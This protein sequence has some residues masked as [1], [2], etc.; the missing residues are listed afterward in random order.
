[1][2]SHNTTFNCDQCDFKTNRKD[3]LLQHNKKGKHKHKNL[4]S[5]SSEK[6]S[7]SSAS[8]GNVP[9]ATASSGNV[10]SSSI[11]DTSS[12]ANVHVDHSYATST[13][14]ENLK[15]EHSYSMKNAFNACIQDRTLYPHQEEKYDFILTFFAKT[16]QDVINFLYARLYQQ[17]LKWYLLVQAYLTKNTEDGEQVQQQ[18]L[19][20]SI[21]FTTLNEGTLNEKDVNE[22]YH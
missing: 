10:L 1:M 12:G 18:P 4:P 15:S 14:T 2:L 19:F 17:A 6:A 13:S 16:K 3:N 20:R 11:K 7:S 8:S 22:A 21:N 9:S 5:I